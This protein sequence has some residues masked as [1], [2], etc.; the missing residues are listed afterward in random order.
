M[1]GTSFLSYFLH[2]AISGFSRDAFTIVPQGLLVK[3]FTSCLST[4]ALVNASIVN[5]AG[6]DG[7]LLV[8]FSF[9]YPQQQH[10]LDLSKFL[11]L[12]QNY[13][14]Y[15]PPL[16]EEANYTGFTD[17]NFSLTIFQWELTTS[18][19]SPPTSAPTTTRMP[20]TPTL[21]PTLHPTYE[22]TQ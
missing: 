20:S 16:A 14:T 7:S 11:S 1:I 5:I 9:L 2:C 4:T 8:T 21:S 10:T 6:V 15:L 12:V 19:T 18:P 13:K 3:G 22:G 17:S